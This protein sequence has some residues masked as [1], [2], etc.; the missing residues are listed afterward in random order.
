MQH[1]LD[2]EDI[3]PEQI[4][5][6]AAALWAAFPEHNLDIGWC[7]EAAWVVLEAL[8]LAEEIVYN[9]LVS[10]DW[11]ASDPNFNPPKEQQ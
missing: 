1:Q 3:I 6:C 2:P 7:R 5:A 4:D 9:Q 10:S 11:P 8:P